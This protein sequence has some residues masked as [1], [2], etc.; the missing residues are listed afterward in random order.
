MSIIA[1]TPIPVGCIDLVLYSPPGQPDHEFYLRIPIQWIMNHFTKPAK[2]LLY[3]GWCIL[4]SHG[5]IIDAQGQTVPLDVEQLQPEG[6]YFYGLGTGA[7][8]YIIVSNRPNDEQ[9]EDLN[10]IDDI[11]NGMLAINPINTLFDK[12][13]V[14]I[15]K[16]PNLVLN[17]EDVS[18]RCT[19]LLTPDPLTE[20]PS[21]TRYTFQYLSN[22][23]HQASLQAIPDNNDAMFA[24]TPASLTLPRPSALLL[25]YNFGV[26]A[27]ENWGHNKSLLYNCLGVQRPERG[28]VAMGPSRVPGKEGRKSLA[29]K[30]KREDDEQKQDKAG[31]SS[32]S[33]NTRT[34]Q[35]DEG[36]EYDAEDIVLFFWGNSKAA[37]ERHQRKEENLRDS[38]EEWKSSVVVE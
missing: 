8:L 14:V 5:E 25:N 6:T 18:P 1:R 20:Y 31:R 36:G 4:G 12:K 37:R 17:M 35:D 27:V 3:S 13:E 19:R 30:R 7:G 10:D 38:V 28:A 24:T 16:T 21:N 2:F 15:I 22:Q 11:R 33:Q 26:A 23:E 9:E 29:E 34:Q 32:T